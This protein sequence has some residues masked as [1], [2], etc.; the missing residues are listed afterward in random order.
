MKKIFQI[1]KK[2]RFD[3]AYSINMNLNVTLKIL[4]LGLDKHG[5][6]PVYLVAVISM[7]IKMNAVEKVITVIENARNQLYC[8]RFIK[9]LKKIYSHLFYCRRK[10]NLLQNIGEEILKYDKF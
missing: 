1:K 5:A 2:S 4:H 10:E 8:E 3:D 9:L 6:D 7:L